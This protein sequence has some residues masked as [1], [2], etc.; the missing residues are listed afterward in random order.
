MQLVYLIFYGRGSI[1][2]NIIFPYITLYGTMFAAHVQ[3]TQ[4]DDLYRKSN[5]SYIGVCAVKVANI[6]R[7]L[8]VTCGQQTLRLNDYCIV[9]ENKVGHK[10]ELKVKFKSLINF[11]VW[12]HSACP[13][14]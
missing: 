14:I 6:A 7:A 10:W 4:F 12:A 1:L 11:L 2:G 5:C 9:W 3:C 8:H 13:C